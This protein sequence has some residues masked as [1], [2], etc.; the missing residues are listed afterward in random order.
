MTSDFQMISCLCNHDCCFLVF[1]LCRSWSKKPP[2]SLPDLLS[3]ITPIL[4]IFSSG[5]GTDIIGTITSIFGST[6]TLHQG[7]TSSR[8]DAY[9]A[10]LRQGSAAVLNSY[11]SRTYP[12]TPL[13]VKS[14][15]RGA[16][17]SQQAA[18]VMATKFENANLGYG[19]RK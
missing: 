18:A 13:Q 8:T 3:F 7:L 2:S 12:F 17:V 1:F 14:A 11:S 16:L 4:D 15:F 9:G 6:T 10:L 5:G 19:A